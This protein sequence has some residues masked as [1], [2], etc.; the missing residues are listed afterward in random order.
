M[1]LYVSGTEGQKFSP[2]DCGM[3]QFVCADIID[4]GTHIS[5]FDGKEKAQKKLA[6]IF[7]LNEKRDDGK[8]YVFAREYTASITSKANLRKDLASWRGRDFT[9]EELDKFDV[10]S[11]KGANGMINIIENHK[12]DGSIGRKIGSV[13]PIVKGMQKIAAE[14]VEIPKWITDRIA[15]SVESKQAADNGHNV[16]G[17]AFGSDPLPQFDGDESGLP[18]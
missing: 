5:T 13:S 16:E 17:Q 14:P 15:E 12:P 18:F 9:A 7:Q 8:R 11:V 10:E 3:Y 6:L 4:L 2:I 1:P